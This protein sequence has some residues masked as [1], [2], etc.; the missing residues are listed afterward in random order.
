MESLL[1]CAQEINAALLTIQESHSQME[2]M[3][4][5]I[6]RRSRGIFFCNFI[7][8]GPIEESFHLSNIKHRLTILQQKLIEIQQRL[9]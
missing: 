2:S 8:Q 4:E 9:V 6:E 5:S 3:L 1:T 7:I